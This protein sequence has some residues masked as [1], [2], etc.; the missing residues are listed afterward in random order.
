MAIGLLHPVLFVDDDP[1]DLML[2]RQVLEELSLNLSIHE[3]HNGREALEYLE[4]AREREQLPSLIVLDIN[5]PVMDGKE[6]L[7]IIRQI[8]AYQDIPTVMFTTSNS[9]LDRLF[10]RKYKVE[11]I[12]KPP[13]YD[14][15]K[16][17]IKRVLSFA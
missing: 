11:M 10:F 13:N 17:A 3:V 16:E 6:T 8:P 1:D 4:K 15:L 12:T 5:M 14:Q 2:I 9:D 7:S